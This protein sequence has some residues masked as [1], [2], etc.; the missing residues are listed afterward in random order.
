VEGASSVTRKEFFEK[1]GPGMSMHVDMARDLEALL[2]D[3]DTAMGGAYK[4]LSDMPTCLP[5]ILDKETMTAY[6]RLCGRSE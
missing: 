1:H 5:D 4:L 2:D 3:Y 6:R